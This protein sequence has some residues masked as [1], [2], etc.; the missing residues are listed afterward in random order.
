[1]Q[2]IINRIK[3]LAV[4]YPDDVAL[5]PP[6]GE[7]RI[8]FIESKLQTKL[9]AELIELY[10]FSNGF[11]FLN[12]VVV[13]LM[14]KRLLNIL[15]INPMTLK[16]NGLHKEVIIFMITELGESFAYTI[17]AN[18]DTFQVIKMEESDSIFKVVAPGIRS[19]L[20]SF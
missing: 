20:K 5:H 3:E 10:N 2:D 7:L 14:N 11:A 6:A 8:E 19:F 15:S 18:S 13:G 9:P 17:D 4:L 16:P 12:Y 1:M